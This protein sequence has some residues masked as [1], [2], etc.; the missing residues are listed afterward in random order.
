MWGFGDLNIE[1]N[2]LL[3]MAISFSFL[4]FQLWQDMMSMQKTIEERNKTIDEQEQK[5]R[6]ASLKQGKSEELNQTVTDQL[7]T[8]EE[9]SKEQIGILTD[10][11]KSL[12]EEKSS[13]EGRLRLVTSGSLMRLLCHFLQRVQANILT[14]IEDFI[15]CLVPR[16]LTGLFLSSIRVQTNKILIY[17]SF[18]Q[19][20]F[21]LSNCQ[22]VKQWDFIDY[23]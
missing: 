13:L 22:L 19:V 5:L 4:C 23:F 6:E 14:E 11:L 15:N 1:V 21:Q 7:K 10:Q 20:N 8:K 18:Q 17:A 12:R 2:V 9:K 16:A 3:I